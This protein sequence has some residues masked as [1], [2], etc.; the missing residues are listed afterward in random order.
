MANAVLSVFNLNKTFHLVPIF[1]GVSSQLNEGE[2]VAL[3]GANGAGK[4]TILE[5]I[6]GFE[7]PDPDSGAIVRARG[8]RLAYLP[9]EV[10]GLGALAGGPPPGEQTTLWEAMLD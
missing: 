7:E 3:V 9:Q 10:A 8:L 5:I 2:K 6:A 1:E 4:T